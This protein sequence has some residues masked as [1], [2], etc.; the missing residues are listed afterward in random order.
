MDK[1][2]VVEIVDEYT[3]IIDYGLSNYA[4]VGRKLRIYTVGEEIQ[5]PTTKLYLGT[6][7]IIKA[8]VEVVTPYER[9]SICKNISYIDY[10]ILNP[11]SNLVRTT[12]SKNKLNV[13]PASISNREL[14]KASPI[15]VGDL[16]MVLN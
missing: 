9:F 12:S 3:L 14:P 13:N 10:N 8:V 7:D 5:D 11:L 1:Y 4:E 16:V 15:E 6:L 2:K